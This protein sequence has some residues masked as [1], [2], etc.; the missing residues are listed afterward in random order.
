MFRKL[1]LIAS[2]TCST[3]FTLAAYADH[4]TD[5]H[6]PPANVPST[7]A[8]IIPAI[9]APPP[10]VFQL[11]LVAPPSTILPTDVTGFHAGP[12]ANQLEPEKALT[13]EELAVLMAKDKR[14]EF[15]A[16]WTP[17]AKDFPPSLPA[18]ASTV[19]D[20]KDPRKQF[21]RVEKIAPLGTKNVEPMF[22][23]TV[24]ASFSKTNDDHLTLRD[25]AVLVRA[26]GRPVFISTKLCH[27]QVVT[28]I[29]NGAIAMI[30]AFDEKPTVLNL[31]DKCCGSVVVY[32]PLE[33]A[34]K[35]HSISLKAG[36]IA[37]AYKLDTKPVS[38][39]VST[40]I[41]VNERIGP[42]CGLL[43]SQCHYIRALKKF[44]L[45]AALPKS[46]FDRIVKT[47]A[48]VGYVQYKR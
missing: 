41:D 37:E 39:L 27:E 19:E 36:Q 29:T 25:G 7:S 11:P 1:F 33:Q 4:D 42:H 10:P 12:D 6:E 22:M 28:C 5:H 16:Q 34:N 40:R 48:A 17:F 43:V 8:P 45:V 23:P 44:N 32:V 18:P 47:A 35:S 30:S 38:H 3:A 26:G 24:N 31:T 21:G 2:F 13:K 14:F 46:D 20:N 15:T 9:A